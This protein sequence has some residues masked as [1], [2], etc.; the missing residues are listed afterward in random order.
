MSGTEGASIDEGPTSYWDLMYVVSL[1]RKQTDSLHTFC[2]GTMELKL[3]QA[4]SFVP[5]P[6]D[7]QEAAELSL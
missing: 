4:A 3:G 2:S 1:S 5:G 7:Q 6:R